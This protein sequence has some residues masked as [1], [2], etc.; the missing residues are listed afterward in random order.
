MHKLA[1]STVLCWLGAGV[2]EPKL[3][4]ASL[5]TQWVLS[6]CWCKASFSLAGLGSLECR[7]SELRPG[8][9]LHA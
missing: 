5:S 4:A 6:L 8:R 1:F 3:C 7:A 9:S 2:S